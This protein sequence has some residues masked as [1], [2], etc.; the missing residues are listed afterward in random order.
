MNYRVGMPGWRLA[1]RVG[2]HLYFRVNVQRDAEA[3]VYCATSPDIVG[4][5]IEAA[6]LDELVREIRDGAADLLDGRGHFDA[7]QVMRLD[8]RLSVA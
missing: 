2:A 4:L 5:V 1:A 8:P 6:T 3:G 7:D